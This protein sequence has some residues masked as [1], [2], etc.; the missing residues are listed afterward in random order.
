MTYDDILFASDDTDASEAALDHALRFADAFDAT[1]HVVYV[2]DVAEPPPG[3]DD[4]GENPEHRAKRRRA[5]NDPTQRAEQAGIDVT[6]AAAQGGD[7]GDTILAY[8][9][10]HD[11]D[12]VVMG[13]HGRSGLDR[14]LVGSVAEHVVRNAPVPVVTA[15]PTST[16]PAATHSEP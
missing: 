16:E 4:P 14:L 15:H 9:R 8:A 1:L 11:I 12:L 10:E 3:F 6:T 13:T 7:T 2:L 5:L